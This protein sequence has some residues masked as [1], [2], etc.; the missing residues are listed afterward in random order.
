MQR[1]EGALTADSV[2][3]ALSSALRAGPVVRAGD[4]STLLH[5]GNLI[6]LPASKRDEIAARVPKLLRE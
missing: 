1:T 3:C 5:S 6:P 2:L 4:R